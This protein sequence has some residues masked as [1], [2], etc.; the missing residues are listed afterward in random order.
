[1]HRSRDGRYCTAARAEND[2]GLDF[3]DLW[4]AVLWPMRALIAVGVTFSF[5]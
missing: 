2:G 1:M 3:P 5:K 4:L